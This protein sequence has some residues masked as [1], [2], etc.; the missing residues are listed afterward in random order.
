[1]VFDTD[2]VV[3]GVNGEL[4]VS[5]TAVAYTTDVASA[6]AARVSAED[7]DTRSWLYEHPCVC[8]GTGPQ[9]VQLSG[10]VGANPLLAALCWLP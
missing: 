1:M 7:I 3:S 8:S 9:W 5:G 2:L 6:F 4:K 10:N